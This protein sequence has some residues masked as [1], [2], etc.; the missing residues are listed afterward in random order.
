MRKKLTSKLPQPTVRDFA[1]TLAKTV[2]SVQPGYGP[3]AAEIF[4]IVIAPPVAKR[5]DEWFEALARAVLDLQKKT[6]RFQLGDLSTNE[7]FITAIMHATTAALKT[8]QKEKL[9]ALRNAVLHSALPGSPSADLQ[10]IFLGWVASLTPTHIWLL[11]VLSEP[12]SWEYAVLQDEK[13]GSTGSLANVIYLGYPA[14]RAQGTIADKVTHDLAN[15]GLVG[16][17]AAHTVKGY[18]VF[19]PQVTDLGKQF[20]AYISEPIL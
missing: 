1:H 8:N 18:I 15:E 7:E 14:L 10:L 17:S 16:S 9:D 13:P 20:I 2:I 11:K 5:R 6:S 12:S 4:N 3:Y 19:A